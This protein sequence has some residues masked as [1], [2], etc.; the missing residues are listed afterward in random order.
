M[1]INTTTLAQ[2]TEQEIRALNPNTSYPV[3]FPVPDGYAV[4]FPAPAVYDPV[5]QIATPATPVLTVKGHYEQAWT[6]TDKDPEQIAAE[7][8]AKCLADIAATQAEITRLEA[9]QLL[10]R[11]TREF[12]LGLTEA[13]YTPEQLAQNY[14]YKKLKEFD[15]QII[16]LRAK[17]V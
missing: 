15:T 4:V 9:E 2:L 1:Y 17:L 8:E 5:T 13:Q 6:I 11:L 14:G 7:A 16:A 10:P 3:P 12:M